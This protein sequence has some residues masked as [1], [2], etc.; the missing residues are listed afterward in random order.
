MKLG[1]VVHVL[2]ALLVILGGFMFSIIPFSLYY[3]IHDIEVTSLTAIITILIGATTWYFTKNTAKAIN[4][5]TGFLIVFFGWLAISFFSALPY[6]FSGVI[7]NFTNAV[8]ES[9]SGLTTTG[10]SVL[11]D[12][13]AVPKDIL[14]WRSLT[15]WLGGMG[16]IVLTVALFPLLG[17]GGIEL[18]V[19]EAPGPTSDKIHPR[20]KETAKRLWFIYFGLTAALIPILWLLGMTFYDAINHALATMAT[21]GFSTKNNSIA[22]YDNMP[23]IQYVITFFMFLA[24]VNYTVI[25]YGLKGNFK[26]VWKSDEFR[27]YFYLVLSLILFVWAVVYNVTDLGLEKSFRDS[28]FQIVSVIT[29]TGYVS[30]DYTT[31]TP[32]LTLLFVSLLFSGACAGSTSGG[33]KIIR[34]LVFFKNISLELKRL[35]HPKAITRIKI[36]KKIVPP[37]I[38][39]HILVFLL[40]YLMLF[41]VG[42]FFMAIV[43]ADYPQPLLT[44]IGAVATCLGNVGPAIGQLSPVDN[45]ANVPLVGKWILIFLMLVGRLELFT[46]LVLFTPFFWK[47]S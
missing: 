2:G 25:Y 41:A 6:I 11:N 24:G 18:F 14:Y 8:F 36:D 47:R 40:I 28:A 23:A 10:A 31:W 19:A 33:I 43:F 22:F 3:S 12:I 4:K 15:Q 13:E 9:V 21:G 44:A 38:L 30:A 20:I 17:I 29:T 46:V 27:T 32:A 35:L 1:I 5:R 45:F 26:Y 7:P 37:K 16:I 34:H 39:M 42:S